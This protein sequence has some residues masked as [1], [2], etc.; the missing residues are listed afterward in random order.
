MAYYPVRIDAKRYRKK[1]NKQA[2]INK[3]FSFENQGL[4]FKVLKLICFRDN[5]FIF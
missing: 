3:I 2:C 4:Y 1:N 5:L